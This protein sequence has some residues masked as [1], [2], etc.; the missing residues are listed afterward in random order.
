LKTKEGE[1]EEGLEI[2]GGGRA[3][4]LD[5]ATRKEIYSFSILS[6]KKKKR[7][8]RLDNKWKFGR[9]RLDCRTVKEMPIKM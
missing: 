2:S 5:F 8:S 3:S 4:C 7:K 1:G 6:V 9:V